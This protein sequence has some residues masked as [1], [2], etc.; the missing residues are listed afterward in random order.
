MSYQRAIPRREAPPLSFELLSAHLKAGHDLIALRS[1]SEEPIHY[2]WPSRPPLS[3]RKARAH[4]MA[5]GNI[6]VRLRPDMLVAEVEPYWGVTN[7]IQWFE[8]TLGVS[9]PRGPLVDCGSTQHLYFKKPAHLRIRRNSAQFPGVRFTSSIGLVMA[10][11]SVH[12]KHHYGRCEILQNIFAN[13]PLAPSAILDRI[14]LGSGGNQ[15]ASLTPKALAAFLR[16]QN[17]I[18]D[19]VFWLM[20]MRAV[21]HATRGAA[22]EQFMAWAISDPSRSRER[23]E[24]VWNSLDADRHELIGYTAGYWR[25]LRSRERR[26]RIQSY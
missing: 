13:A 24:A 4:M 8:N 22:R 12:P 6:G 3:A 15:I 11:G 17:A 14:A 23:I 9:L 19:D 18:D 25:S 5:G 26:S 2:D 20:F 1:R 16:N 10:G 21:Y 7:A